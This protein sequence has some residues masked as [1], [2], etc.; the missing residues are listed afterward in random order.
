[1]GAGIA[2]LEFSV[3]EF[4]EAGLLEPAT[5]SLEEALEIESTTPSSLTFDSR[6]C[7]RDIK[8]E[9][10]F[11]AAQP[12]A[13][14][15]SEHGSL[16]FASLLD[17]SNSPQLLAAPDDLQPWEQRNLNAAAHTTQAVHEGTVRETTDR[18]NK[19]LA[20]NRE[21]QRRFK[22]RQQVRQNFQGRYADLNGYHQCIHES[23]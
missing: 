18:K 4:A 3:S 11:P 20:Q 12:D 14:S 5:L 6:S 13:A 19:K 1:M 8:P 23:H 15:Q 10:T 7:A 22:M 16:Q 21:H 2:E 9:S 17:I